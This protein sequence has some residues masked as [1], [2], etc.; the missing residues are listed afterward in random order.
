[1]N[2]LRERHLFRS[3]GRTLVV[4]M[5]HSRSYDSVTGLKNPNAVISAV[6][7]G[8]ADAVLT[9]YGTAEGAAEVLGSTG[10]WLSVDTTPQTVTPIIERAVR[11]GVDGIKA[12]LYPWCERGDDHLGS[13][14]GKE[15]VMNMVTLAAECKKW[16]LPLMAEVIP[17]GWP[18][19]DKR[20]PEITAAACRVASETGANF[21]KSFYTGDK[22]SFKT[23]VDNCSVPVLVLGGPK[24]KSDRD[25]LL[26][27]R[28]AMDAGAI[29]IC[30]GRNI[31]GHDNIMGIT[32]ALA[33]IIH[34][35]ASAE[36][37]SNFI[38]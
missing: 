37:A 27:V 18:G 5:D 22:E 24:A 7:A 36:T 11:L 32:A 16:G 33:A 2:T 19:A 29:G 10:L 9:P 6:M 35:D 38:D 12:E 21:V 3:S 23:L 25:T 28:D 8:G 1:M 26:M 17:F 30:I 13:Y 14:T 15:T 31:W 20:T 34:D 4:A